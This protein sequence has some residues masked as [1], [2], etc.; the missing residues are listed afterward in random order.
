LHG[1]VTHLKPRESKLNLRQIAVA[2]KARWPQ[3]LRDS[4]VFEF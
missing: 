3:M 2:R 1:F 4:R